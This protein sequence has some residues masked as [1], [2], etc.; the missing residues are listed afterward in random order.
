MNASDIETNP[1]P[2]TRNASNREPADI[3]T[4]AATI[5]WIRR[6]PTLLW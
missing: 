4:T 3:R 5:P 2:L 6:L 1:K